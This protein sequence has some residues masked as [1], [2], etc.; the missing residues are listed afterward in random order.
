MGAACD[1]RSAA[2]DH[3][4]ASDMGETVAGVGLG[5][6]LG[7]LTATLAEAI[8]AL[9]ALRSTRLVARSSFYRSV[10]LDAF[11]P[12]FLNAVV[13]IETALS[14]L[15]LLTELQRIEREHGRQ[16]PFRNAP[17][18]LDLDLLFYGDVCLRSPTLTVPH[19]RLQLRAFVLQP[20]AE[21]AANRVLPGLGRVADLLPAV[22]GQHITRWTDG[23]A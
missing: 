23:P 8:D 1:V 3:F 14:P 7:D 15:A 18:T 9:A 20:L 12:D 13:L 11:G 2:P 10:P 5:A 4:T 22:A 17:R 6:N 21:I 16:R 19:P